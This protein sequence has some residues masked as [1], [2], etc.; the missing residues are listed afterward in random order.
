MGERVGGTEEIL[1]GRGFAIG[2]GGELIVVDTE[3]ARHAQHHAA[4]VQVH[5][6]LLIADGQPAFEPA[7]GMEDEV[8]P[9]QDTGHH[10]GGGFLHGLAVRH[11][12]RGQVAAAAQ[13]QAEPAAELGDAKVERLASGVPKVGAPVLRFMVVRKLP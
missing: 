7:G 11:L 13:R 10:A 4:M 6:E 2:I 8:R 3:P 12:R 1:A 9:G 5:D